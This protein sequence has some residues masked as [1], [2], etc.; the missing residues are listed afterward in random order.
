MK[1]KGKLRSL[2]LLSL[3]PM[4]G[5]HL[6]IPFVSRVPSLELNFLTHHDLPDADFI[7]CMIHGPL[8]NIFPC[9]NNIKYE[10]KC[11]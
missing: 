5:L 10:E 2:S 4:R 6:P 1:E 8:Q 9:Q 3:T 11:P 7:Q